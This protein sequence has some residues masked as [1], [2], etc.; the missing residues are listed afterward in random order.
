MPANDNNKAIKAPLVVAVAELAEIVNQYQCRYGKQIE[1]VH[2]NGNTYQI[3]NKYDIT[4]GMRFVGYIFPFENK[5]EYQCRT[6]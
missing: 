6:E 2:G 4:V 3:G 5:P 1:Q